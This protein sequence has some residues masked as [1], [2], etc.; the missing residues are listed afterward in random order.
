MQANQPITILVALTPTEFEQLARDV[1]ALV[2]CDRTKAEIDVAAL[3]G[4]SLT[5]SEIAQV[6]R[7]LA[8]YF[9]E[10]AGRAMDE[11]IAPRPLEPEVMRD[12]MRQHLR[13]VA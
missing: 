12:W 1:F 7:L 13:P 3:T 10:L 2:Q 4:K 9:G 8:L 5:T 11:Q 6:R